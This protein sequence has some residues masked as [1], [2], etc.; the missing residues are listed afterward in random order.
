M[1]TAELTRLEEQIGRLLRL[2]VLACAVML[3][4]G[5]ILSFTGSTASV[6]LLRIGLAVLMA[7]PVTRIVASFVDAVRRRDL[8]LSS[9]TA[10]VLLVMF[11]TLVYSL[12]SVDVDAAEEVTHSFSVE[13]TLEPKGD[14]M[15][16]VATADGHSQ[17]FIVD[18]KRQTPPVRLLTHA[19]ND[20]DPAWSPD[21]SRIAF[22]SDAS[23][24]RQVFVVNTDGSDLRQLTNEGG[25]AIHPS[26]AP[27]GQRLAYSVQLNAAGTPDRFELVEVGLDGQGRRLITNDGGEATFPSWAP[28][29]ARLAF[30][31]LVGSNSEIFVINADG[32]GEQDLSN[33]SSYDGW[34]AWSPDGKHIAFASNRRS[35][36]QIFIMDTDGS[37]QTLVANTRG[38]ATTPRW[39]FDSKAIYFTNCTVSGTN[40]DCRILRA[41]LKGP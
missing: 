13:L 40:P 10:I 3:G 16:Y 11:G 25:P 15:A 27:D 39:T 19:D 17:L 23:G 9:S 8:L 18:L 2:G 6:W 32:T 38:S 4:L 5:L 37:H 28:D 22:V 31:K 20:D 30:R 41:D 26:W 7:I 14:R 35:D 1:S 29:G 33:D 24:S 12:R 36:Y 34:P 21:G